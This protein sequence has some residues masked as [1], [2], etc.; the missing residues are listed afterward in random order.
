MFPLEKNKYA[1]DACLKFVKARTRVGVQP[2]PENEAT[3]IRH[4]QQTFLSPRFAPHVQ[5]LG[6]QEKETFSSLIR[7]QIIIISINKT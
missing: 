6:V 3:M 4:A 1:R 7:R 2:L 5:T